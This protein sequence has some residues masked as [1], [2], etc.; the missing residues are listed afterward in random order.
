M[1]D[2]RHCETAQKIKKMENCNY[3]LP[4]FKPQVCAFNELGKAA[5]KARKSFLDYLRADRIELIK[6]GLIDS[7]M[8]KDPE[9]F[10]SGCELEGTF[11]KGSRCELTR[12]IFFERDET[13]EFWR[14]L[15]VK[16]WG[17]N[18]YNLSLRNKLR[19]INP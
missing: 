17:K 2:W 19:L 14:R 4:E 16:F 7:I 15:Y 8:E 10:C 12:E 1:R 5:K 3:E 18:Y 6:S 13:R 11:C 9:L